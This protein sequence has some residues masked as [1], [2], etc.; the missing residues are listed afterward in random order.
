MHPVAHYRVYESL[1]LASILSQMNSVQNFP[2]Y[3]F[4][5]YFKIIFLSMRTSSLCSLSWLGP[6]ADLK[7]LG[8]RL[9]LLELD[10]WLVPVNT[11][12]AIPY[13]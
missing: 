4:N 6:R 5:I 2:S 13:R 12:W 1:P 3:Y 10:I 7:N 9:R 8:K 11:E